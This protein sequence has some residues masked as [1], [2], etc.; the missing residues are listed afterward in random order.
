MID[1][2]LSSLVEAT[3]RP[4]LF[5]GVMTRRVLM[6]P[7]KLARPIS[8]LMLRPM[9]V[10]IR[11]TRVTR[12]RRGHTRPKSTHHRWVVHW[13]MWV[14]MLRHI[15]IRIHRLHL[16]VRWK[17]LPWHWHWSHIVTTHWIW[18]HPILHLRRRGWLWHRISPWGVHHLSTR[19]GERLLHHLRN[20]H[21]LP[22]TC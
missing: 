8:H 2:L 3:G 5:S 1:F 12:R 22:L 14:S 15:T 13:K 6:L 18:W 19:H 10:R 16:R 20:L 4:T 7:M 9:L 21:L 11:W 17:G